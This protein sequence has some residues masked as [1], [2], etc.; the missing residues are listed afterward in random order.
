[1]AKKRE[2]FDL[3]L[4]PRFKGGTAWDLLNQICTTILEEPKRYNQEDWLTDVFSVWKEGA[5]K[6]EYKVDESVLD[7]YPM[8]GTIGCVAGWTVSM[9]DSKNTGGIGETAAKILGLTKEQADQLFSGAA[10]EHTLER[11]NQSIR[12]VRPGTYEYAVLG[13]NHIQHFMAEHEEQLKATVIN[14]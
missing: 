7:D 5:Y 3:T 8:C 9:T 10:I 14:A 4:V 6:I 2:E 12:Q 11:L 1:M 13:A